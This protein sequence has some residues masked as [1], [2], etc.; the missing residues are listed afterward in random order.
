MSEYRRYYSG[1]YAL[2]DKKRRNIWLNLDNESLAHDIC[3]VFVSKLSLFVFDL[4]IFN[5]YND[6]LI[7]SECCLD[8]QIPPL[9]RVELVSSSVFE[10]DALPTVTHHPNPVLVNQP[11]DSLLEPNRQKE[12]QE[13]IMLYI[14]L[15]GLADQDALLPMQRYDPRPVLSNYLHMLDQCFMTEIHVEDIKSQLINQCQQCL[16]SDHALNF[17]V[18]SFFNRLYE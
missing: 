3:R 1:K 5:N 2:V 10:Y 4:T 14:Q 9:D 11:S 15:R 6:Q 7:D 13:Q 17:H 18:L 12:L 8:W 16:D